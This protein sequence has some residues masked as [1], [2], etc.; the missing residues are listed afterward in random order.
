MVLKLINSYFQRNV[1]L[2]QCL[3]MCFL[4]CINLRRV[5]FREVG[6]RRLGGGRDRSQ[7]KRIRPRGT[8]VPGSRLFAAVESVP[9]MH[10]VWKIRIGVSAHGIGLHGFWGANFRQIVRCKCRTRDFD[11]SYGSDLLLCGASGN[12][13][14]EEYGMKK[15]H[16]CLG[17][18][19]GA[20]DAESPTVSLPKST[21][22]VT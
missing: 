9:L 13:R 1:L 21:V 20:S 16:G 10:L 2:E 19:E 17:L 5:C 3:C 14:K 12:Q 15:L 6:R 8:I 22:C 18:L 4:L 11:A 7:I